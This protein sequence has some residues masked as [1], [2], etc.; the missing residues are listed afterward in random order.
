[1]LLKPQGLS[2]CEKRF[3]GKGETVTAI[4]GFNC[5]DGVVLAADSEETFDGGNKVFMHK[6]FP[7]TRPTWRACVVGSGTGYLIDY[8]K[9]KII[10]AI[11]A[12]LKNEDE[13]QA[14]LGRLLDGLYSK[15]FKRYPVDSALQRSIQ[16]L[17]GV[18]FANDSNAS[19]W[20][21]PALFECQSNL[22]TKV[23]LGGARV[24]GI[25]E[26]VKE[27]GAQFATWRLTSDLAEWASIYVIH[28]AKKRF[29][30]VGGKT[31]TFRIR[32]DGTFVDRFG[33]NIYQA[34]HIFDGLAK[35]NQLLAFSLSPSIPDSKSKD[36]V[37]TAKTWLADARRHMKEVERKQGKE[38]HNLIEIR[39]RQMEKM[40]K[41]ISK[42]LEVRDMD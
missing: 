31:H 16:L 26:A 5:I 13:V 42:A 15:E 27:L 12:G 17:V 37:D 22:V 39:D 11:H 1:V 9:D 18:Q 32:Q 7:F 38:R 33:G 21:Q 24:L 40:I 28:E 35:I 30:G 4:A 34:E 8:A 6:L 3:P 2:I 41:H 23:S 36:L 29:G 25:G 20:Q 19:A 10:A 14:A